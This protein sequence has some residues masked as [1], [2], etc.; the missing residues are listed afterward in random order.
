MTTAWVRHSPI[1]KRLAGIDLGR[2]VL[3]K[4]AAERA[5]SEHLDALL[6]PTLPVRWVANPA[7][8][9][10]EAHQ[11]ALRQARAT[12]KRA[13]RHARWSGAVASVRRLIRT[14][15]YPAA[16]E[17]ARYRMPPQV[18]MVARGAIADTERAANWTAEA[19][20]LAILAATAQERGAFLEPFARAFEAGLF[21]LWVTRAEVI[22]C[23]RPVVH[24]LAGRPHNP[25]GPA[26][27]WEGAA[28]YWFLHGAEVPDDL[29]TTPAD[30]FNPR[31]ILHETNAEVR[32][33]IARKVG[34]QRIA[35][36]FGTTTIDR[37]SS[38]EL[39]LLRIDGMR[40]VYLSMLNPST[41]ERHIEAVH[42]S[43]RSVA[44]AL[45]W[46]NG[47]LFGSPLRLT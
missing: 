36:A 17:T 15:K 1:I 30:Q 26:I 13:V 34:M 43:C 41:G 47:G 27:E 11:S 33:E 22:A 39:L 25:A 45:A 18:R 19:D 24:L 16:T 6:L 21:L 31:R 10:V 35:K 23:P 46:R 44:E 3:D 20:D 40:C 8:G 4:E 7:A 2:A 32:K 28:R 5:L 12:G 9:G 42:P 14:F 38:Y 29:V 37:E